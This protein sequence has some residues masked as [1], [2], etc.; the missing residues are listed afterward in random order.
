M[1]IRARAVAAVCILWAVAEAAVA[2]QPIIYPAKG[3][4]QQ[5]QNADLAQCQSWANQTTGIDPAAVRQQAAN[6]PQQQQV[7]GERVVG[8]AGGALIGGAIGGGNAAVGG[9]LVGTML[10]GARQRQKQKQNSQQQQQAQYN[11]NSQLTTYYR[12]LGACMEARGYTVR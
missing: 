10:G 7:G 5:Q 4:N 2:Q 12:A 1:S 9:A 8:A 11:A 6:Q 3:Q